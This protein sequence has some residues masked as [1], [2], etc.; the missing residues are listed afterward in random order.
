MRFFTHIAF[1]LLIALALPIGVDTPY[2]LIFYLLG[3]LFPDIDV[4]TSIIGKRI[5]PV[6]WL[7]SHRGIFHSLPMLA[8]LSTIIF[9]LFGKAGIV[10]GIGYLTHL[11]LDML[12]HQGIRLLYPAG[13]VKGFMKTG[14]LGEY[15]LLA[16]FILGGILLA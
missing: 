9:V 3:S 7:F 11:L 8:M 10:F 5:K 12:N 15:T 14:G 16:I 2:L 4:S 13:R 6:G 1:S